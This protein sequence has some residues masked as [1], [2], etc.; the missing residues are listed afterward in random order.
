VRVLTEAAQKDRDA[1]LKGLSKRM[2]E[3][4]KRVAEADA[5]TLWGEIREMARNHDYRLASSILAI[6]EA[7]HW[8][9]MHTALALAYAHMVLSNGHANDLRELMTAITD[10]L[11]INNG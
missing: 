2:G 11:E 3:A 6:G 5:E 10:R 8:T 7:E 9:V 4:G 1:M